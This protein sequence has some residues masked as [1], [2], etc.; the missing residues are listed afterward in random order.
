M[1]G[2]RVGQWQTFKPFTQAEISRI[3]EY[4]KKIELNFKFTILDILYSDGFGNT[5][6][7]FL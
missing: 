1:D 3:K 4:K 5:K 7:I 6:G 2:I